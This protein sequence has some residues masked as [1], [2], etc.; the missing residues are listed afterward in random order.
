MVSAIAL[1]HQLRPEF[2]KFARHLQP[3]DASVIHHYILRATRGLH[4]FSRTVDPLA[5][6]LEADA[7]I[8]AQRIGV[9][10]LDAEADQLRLLLAE[11]SARF[12]QGGPTE[13]DV[14]SRRRNTE[15]RHPTDVAVGFTPPSRLLR[16]MTS[17]IASTS[18]SCGARS[19]TCSTA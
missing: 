8:Q 10:G 5:N 3:R 15:L 1:L 4:R 17:D 2:G 11:A 9:L 7:A 18:S 14:A 13:T 6:D 16:S 19:S 12:D